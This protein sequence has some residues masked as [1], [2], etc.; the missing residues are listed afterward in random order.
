MF[1]KKGTLCEKKNTIKN[2]KKIKKEITYYNPYIIL[3]YIKEIYKIHYNNNN[4]NNKL[5]ITIYSTIQYDISI[6][7]FISKTPSSVYIIELLLNEHDTSF[8]YTIQENPFHLQ[9]TYTMYKHILEH[10]SFLNTIIHFYNTPIPI[11]YINTFFLDNIFNFNT[12]YNT[13]ITFPI[14]HIL[15]V[16]Y[17]YTHCVSLE[18]KAF[19]CI[20]H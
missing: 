6:L 2:K 4:N 12:M 18:N 20:I 1:L 16:L 11:V 15:H 14:S 13:H 5:P 19:F 9:M 10:L 17:T 7:D 3:Q 8:L